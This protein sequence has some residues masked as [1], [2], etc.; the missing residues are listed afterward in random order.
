[1]HV[2]VAIGALHLTLDVSR[3]RSNQSHETA[4]GERQR[5][6][7]YIFALQQYGKALG[8]LS[9]I[10]GQAYQSE[11]H[12]RH[13]LISSLLTTCFE[14]YIGNK[15][16]A[17]T[18]AKAGIDLLI[19]WTAKHQH[20][21]VDDFGDEWSG[22]KRLASRSLYLDED[23]L[24][25]FERLDYQL[26]LCEG[27][28]P[29]RKAPRAFPSA[30]RPF[31]SLKEASTF[32]DLVVRRV[33]HF[34]VVTQPVTQHSSDVYYDEDNERISQMKGS[35]WLKHAQ[36]ERQNFTTTTEQFFRFFKPIF[37]SSRRRP[38]SK[39]YLLANLVMVRALC[40][41]VVLS[42][43]PSESEIYPDAFLRDYMLVIGLARE[44]IE[45]S[46]T[47]LG[48]AV[49]NFDMSLGYSIF[50]LVNHCRDPKVRR[51]GIELLLQY[52]QREG[53]FETIVAAKIS[54]WLMKK[55]EEGMVKGFIPD[56]VRLR[57]VKHE[58]GPQ[59]QLVV[60]YYSKLVWK[61]GQS[62]REIL[63]P[64]TITWE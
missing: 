15:S 28:P 60:L 56:P 55:E 58:V 37:D 23:L 17:V 6:S 52:P 18:Q 33:L 47:T 48:R 38:G 25:A 2:V 13:A 36:A 40:A 62:A 45:D 21:A 61:D 44:L 16:N 54:I 39:E 35:V 5:K 11:S 63:P 59:K 49:F 24:E 4:D 34:Y 50:S 8:Q 1:M 30:G 22:I 53:W 20:E 26:L 29:G 57:L 14:T 31:K 51:E 19:K 27:L 10:S 42:R 3:T 7:H 12:L 43:G 9:T 32:W 64:V 41:R 46:K